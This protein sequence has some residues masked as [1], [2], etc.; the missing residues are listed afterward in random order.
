MTPDEY[1]QLKAFARVD[2]LYVS[3]VWIGSFAC[4]VYG[5]TSPLT[6]LFGMIAALVSP[7]YAGKRLKKYRDDVCEGTISFARA[8]FYYLSIFMYA[9][10]LFAVA[11][12]IY[13]EFLDNGHLVNTIAATLSS[14]EAGPLLKAYGLDMKQ[15]DMALAELRE[16]SPIF[17]AVNVLTTNI[18]IGAV[19]S[20]PAAAILKKEKK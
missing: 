2:G 12:Y 10:L 1:K 19:L 6:S 14:P 9:S 20:I 11:Q 4:Y 3:L 18:M 8:A 13:F 16:I 17:F 15:V 5:L 7:F